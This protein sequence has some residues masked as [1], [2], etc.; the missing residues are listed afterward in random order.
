[1]NATLTAPLSSEETNYSTGVFCRLVTAYRANPLQFNVGGA[2]F[3]IGKRHLAMLRGLAKVRSD[4]AALPAT[5]GTAPAVFLLE[6]LSAVDQ[7]T[8]RIET[9]FAA[10]TS[11]A[12]REAYIKAMVK[13]I[14]KPAPATAAATPQ[15]KA[16]A[17]MPAPVKPASAPLTL[18]QQ[19]AL[20]TT[21]EAKS[22]FL[23]KHREQ[24]L[25][26]G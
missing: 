22:E 23:A 18:D 26:R 25:K 12:A 10:L 6:T 19:F 17:P 13:G 11:E 1:M 24:I 2:L 3:N 4:I 16:P 7:T 14:T 5:L 8:K 9:E 21:A 15:A 20:L